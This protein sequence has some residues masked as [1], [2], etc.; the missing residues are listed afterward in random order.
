MHRTKWALIFFIS[1][2]LLG[3][4]QAFAGGQG[5]GLGSGNPAGGT[6]K[7]GQ[8]VNNQPPG[9]T[10]QGKKNGWVK[11]GTTMPVGVQ[12]NLESK[13]KYPKGLQKAR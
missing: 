10:G 3:A 5:K 4:P 7:Q 13:G 9:W 2:A 6:P 8:W 11:H 1:L 12:R